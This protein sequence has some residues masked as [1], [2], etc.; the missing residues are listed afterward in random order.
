MATKQE[1]SLFLESSTIFENLGCQEAETKQMTEPSLDKSNVNKHLHS[2]KCRQKLCAR[3]KNLDKSGICAVCA[4]AI[5][6]ASR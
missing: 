5:I 6:E 2:I 1:T 4:D 3:L